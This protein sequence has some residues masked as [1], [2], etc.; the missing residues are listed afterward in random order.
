MNL[1]MLSKNKDYIEAD[2]EYVV[3][4]K[5]IIKLVEMYDENIRLKYEN[6][7]LRLENNRLIGDKY[8]DNRN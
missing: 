2:L 1:E 3:K 7:L 5:E 8:G 6:G 4:Y